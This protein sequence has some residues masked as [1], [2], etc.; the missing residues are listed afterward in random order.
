V[1]DRAHRGRG[2]GKFGDAL[3]NIGQSNVSAYSRGLMGYQTPN[4]DLAMTS[5]DDFGA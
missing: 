5:A 3:S 4:I 1:Q 2:S